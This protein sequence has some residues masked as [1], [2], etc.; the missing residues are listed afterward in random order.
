MMSDRTHAPEVAGV[1]AGGDGGRANI[2]PR[3]SGDPMYLE[4]LQ[5]TDL[6]CFRHAQAEPEGILREV[7]NLD[8]G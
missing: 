7:R 1:E 5:I 2:C 8:L 6:R 3:A 4:S